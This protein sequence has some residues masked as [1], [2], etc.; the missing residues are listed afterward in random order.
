VPTRPPRATIAR[1]PGQPTQAPRV[2]ARKRGYD[3]KWQEARAGF[4]AKHPRCECPQHK[5]RLD[6]PASDTIDHVTPH[7]GDWSL[8][9]QRSNWLAV[10]K[11][12]NSR[13]AAQS[14][15]GFGNPRRSVV[16]YD[17]RQPLP[18][19]GDD[20]RQ[21]MP[22]PG[23]DG[24]KTMHP[25]PAGP[26]GGLGRAAASFSDGGLPTGSTWPGIR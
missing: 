1:V 13:K 17:M 16:E 15:G 10:A 19:H 26:R 24:N 23:G 9:W 25:P 20:N 11:A 8:F 7:K 5:G 6:A 14:E 2:S 21:T 3:S 18:T 12:C 4:L 22:S